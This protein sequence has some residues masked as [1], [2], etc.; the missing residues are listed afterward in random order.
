METM[1]FEQIAC[2]LLL[3]FLGGVRYYFVSAGADFPDAR[4]PAANWAW[5]FPAYLT[6]TVWAVYVALLILFP[7]PFV[8]WDRWPLGDPASDLLFWVSLP[9]MLAGAWLFWHSHHTIGHYWNIRI[10]LKKSHQ[11]V[12]NG[13]YAWIRH[14]LYTALFLGYAGTL[15]ALQSWLLAAWFPVFVA[16]YLIFAMEE[17]KV[18]ARAFGAAYRAYRS[19]TGMFLPAW[20]R[21]WT[22]AARSLRRLT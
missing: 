10:Q 19:R 1:L 18:M 22:A 7:E 13:P 14:P 15:L 4:G 16:S 11:L 17:E 12:T 6:S 21:L 20:P 8:A 9:L 5:H 2:A 3:L